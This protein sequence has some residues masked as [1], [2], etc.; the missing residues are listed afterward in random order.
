MTSPNEIFTTLIHKLQH[1]RKS[2]DM[3]FY[4]FAGDRI[5]TTIANIL[6][7]KSRQGVGVRVIVDGYGSRNLPRHIRQKMIADGVKFSFMRTYGHCRNH[8]KMVIIDNMYGFVGGINIADRYI[9]GN[10][11]GI[12]HD[13]VLLL[14]G[15]AVEELS[16][17]FEYDLSPSRS[18]QPPITHTLSSPA[19][20]WSES[21]GGDCM[22]RLLR[23][24]C[25]SAEREVIITTP[26][27]IP[28]RHTLD[29]LHR[30]IKR[31]VRVRVIIPESCDISI[32]D[33]VIRHCIKEA[34]EIGVEVL[35][36]QGS[37]I[38]AKMALVDHSR[39][40]IGSANLDAR[41]LSINRELMLSTSNREV[42]HRAKLFLDRLQKLA[43]PAPT[44]GYKGYLPKFV[45][46]SIIP[47][48]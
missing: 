20:Y 1:A 31:G 39:V 28:P 44:C 6:C 48:M 17:L 5:G 9:S 36:V 21:G 35:S 45:I 12:W 33:S 16:K 14:T 46:R 10:R 15:S 26:Y 34:H 23:D 8:R 37:F 27:F 30:A 42:C 18:K 29:I 24:V 4:I 7:R 47:L 41:S 13:A 2:I 11:L 25:D 19:L 38:H 22:L 40:V 3:E 32:L 43:I